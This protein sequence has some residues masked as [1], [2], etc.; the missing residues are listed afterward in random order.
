MQNSENNTFKTKTGYCQVLPDKIVLSR[1]GISGNVA[2]VIVGRNI[3][4]ALIIYSVVTVILFYSAIEKYL[5]GKIFEPTLL[6][7]I[8]LLL[9]Y[10]ILGSLNNS[11]TPLIVRNRITDVQLKKGIKGLTRARFEILFKD[12][13]EKIK[14][15]LIMLPGS[16]SGGSEEMESALKIMKDEKLYPFNKM[17]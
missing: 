3:S 17:K 12:Q 7:A 6:I 5:D 2:E 10:S 4:Q 13:N 11:A 16:L 1:D 8:G 9:L 15:R 14:K